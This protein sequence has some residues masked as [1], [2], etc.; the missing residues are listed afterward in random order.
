MC[1]GLVGSVAAFAGV[2]EPLGFG[3]FGWLAAVAETAEVVPAYS[4]VACA[5]DTPQTNRASRQAGRKVSRSRKNE[6]REPKNIFISLDPRSS[7]NSDVRASRSD[8]KLNP[9]LYSTG[10]KLIGLKVSRRIVLASRPKLGERKD[11]VTKIC[12][13]GYASVHEW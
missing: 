12:R 2:A 7:L 8:T 6:L 5:C 4:A 13:E 9:F 10:C 1:C 11:L 3:R